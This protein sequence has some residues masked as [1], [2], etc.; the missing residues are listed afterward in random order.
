M[1]LDGSYIFPAPVDASWRLL[2]DIEAI[3]RCLPGSRGL[4]PLGGDRYQVELGV[5]IAAIGGQFSG[6][7]AIQD[8]HAPE[9]YTLV[10][11]GSGRPGFVKGRA[12]VTL[13]PEGTGTRVRIA[14]HAEVGGTIARVG[15]RLLEGVGRA[16]MDRF[17]G[18]LAQHARGAPFPPGTR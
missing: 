16:M 12:H 5:A 9:A 15:Q 14:A 8:Q 10:V 1:D 2:M 13:A 7:V 6:T 18:C 4:R 11:D 17:F 3:G